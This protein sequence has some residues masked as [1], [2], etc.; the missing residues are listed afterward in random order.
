MAPG[1]LIDSRVPEIQPL[2]EAYG[3][4]MTAKKKNPAKKA[5]AKRGAKTKYDPD[6][7]PFM[8]WSLAIRG[9]IDKEIAAGLGISTSTLHEW[10]KVHED[11]ASSIK[12]GKGVANSQV[13]QALFKR[14]IGYEYEETKKSSNVYGEERTERTTKQVVPDT[15]A[16]IFWLKNRDPASWRDKQELEHTGKDGA[17]LHPKQM[18][19]EEII[20]LIR[21]ERAAK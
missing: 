21:K 16:Q 4:P 10:K 13:E 19:D 1:Y 20:A 5:P 14:A 6:Y 2:V 3:E 17:P 15:T 11:F 18:S 8:A 7:H 9:K 12:A